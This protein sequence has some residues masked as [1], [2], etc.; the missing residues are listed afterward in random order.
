MDMIHKNLFR[1]TQCFGG[2]KIFSGN[3]KLRENFYTS[4]FQVSYYYHAYFSLK[5]R[6]TFCP[7]R[8]YL[9]LRLKFI[10]L[11][12][13]FLLAFCLKLDWQICLALN[14]WGYF[15]LCKKCPNTEFFLVRI[16]P[17][18]DRI[19]LNFRKNSAFDTFY[20]VSWSC[21]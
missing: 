16:F 10:C 20:A 8:N 7:L 4:S 5:K 6:K 11:S 19:L 2:Y 21:Y 9:V 15:T 12:T 17:H 3:N 18:L 14:L 1:K 13:F